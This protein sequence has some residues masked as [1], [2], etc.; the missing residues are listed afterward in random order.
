M[1]E[2]VIQL[3]PPSSPAKAM[4]MTQQAKLAAAIMKAGITSPAAWAVAGV[5]YGGAA[6]AQAG[7]SKTVTGT[8]PAEE[9]ELTPK[10]VLMKGTHNPD[11]F[12]SWQS[13]RDVVKSLSW[14]SALM[15]WGGPALTLFCVYVLA[16]QFGWL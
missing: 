3:S 12:I 7:E 6:T 13:Q 2:E 16:T 9:F 11:F 4:D 5:P 15:I 1:Q 10:T 14:K 8:A